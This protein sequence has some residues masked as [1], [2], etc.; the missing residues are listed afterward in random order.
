MY[1]NPFSEKI[2]DLFFN[3]RGR[4]SRK[5]FIISLLILLFS[6]P[7]LYTLSINLLS[8]FLSYFVN[9]IIFILLLYSLFVVC[10]KRL[11]DINQSPWWSLLILTGPISLIFFLY[12][13]IAKSSLYKENIEEDMDLEDENDLLNVNRDTL[14][15]EEDLLE[16]DSLHNTQTTSLLSTKNGLIALAILGGLFLLSQ[17]KKGKNINNLSNSSQ[18]VEAMINVLPKSI[19]E[20]VKKNKRSVG[21]LFIKDKFIGAGATITKNRILVRGTQIKKII[22]TALSINQKVEIRFLDNSLAHVTKLIASNDSFTVQMA[23]FEIDQDIG[24]P[25]RLAD[26]NKKLLEEINAFN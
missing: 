13:A 1:P 10:I 18:G 6:G 7:I 8:L 25:G 16:G 11:R 9:L 24:V 26:K 14:E 19:Q 17:W 22:Q 21:S 5:P 12:L 23:V 20:E 2:K 4:I 3:H 15:D